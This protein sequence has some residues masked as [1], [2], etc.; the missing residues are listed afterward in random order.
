[1][2]PTR[3]A[4]LRK[5]LAI[6][7]ACAA[8]LTLPGLELY[9][10]NAD[11]FTL[12]SSAASA[13][14]LA[15]FLLCMSAGVL[16][17]TLAGKCRLFFAATAA[18]T[19][20]AL[21]M[22][23]Q[24]RL[25]CDCFPVEVHGTFAD[26]LPLA[27]FHA[28]MFLLPFV[29]ALVW[30]KKLYRH[31]G[32][33]AL[34]LLLVQVGSTLYPLC[35]RRPVAE[36]DFRE[37]TIDESAKFTFGKRDNIIVLVVDCMSERLAKQALRRYPELQ[38]LLKDFTAFDNMTSP[39]PR[40]PYA[41]PA[42][43]T[44]VEFPANP[45]GTP[46]DADHA[47]YLNRACRAPTSLFI[48]L[49]RFGFRTEGY[50]YIL[51]TVSYSP[52]VLDNS[53]PQQFEVQKDSA[54][55]IA[56][57]V[58]QRLIP[59]YLR[60]LVEEYYCIATDPFVV[61]QTQKKRNAPDEIFDQ[62]FRRRLNDEFTVGEAEKMFKYL[63]LHGA[64]TALRT[65]EDL[66]PTPNSDHLKQLRGSLINLELL[67]AKLKQAGL[68]DRAMLVV[69][70]DHTESYTPETITF[71]K[72]PGERHDALVFN[73]VPAKVK[74]IDAAILAAVDPAYAGQSLFDRPARP[75]DPN[76]ARAFRQAML[77][78]GKW[79]ADTRA[80]VPSATEICF[81][82]F[83]VTSDRRIR[84]EIE[85]AETLR[86]IRFTVENI[87][88]H[89]RVT[90]RSGRATGERCARTEPLELADGIYRVQL[91]PEYDTGGENSIVRQV[92][93]L[94]LIA[95]RGR[96]TF[97]GLPPDRPTRP[98]RPGETVAF[99][100]MEEYPQLV[101]PETAEFAGRMLRL[102][103]GMALGVRIPRSDRAMTLELAVPPPRGQ[104]GTLTVRSGDRQTFQFPIA[105]D[106]DARIRIPVAAGAERIVPVRLEFTPR[107]GRRALIT[108]LRH[109]AVK[110]LRLD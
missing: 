19:A 109:I 53:R 81:Q 32:R 8:V 27:G 87:D 96:L 77:E 84:F 91:E 63:H 70:G 10:A 45:D 25:W 72:R 102:P 88:T 93:P 59:F 55:K 54:I 13:L 100:P 39:L 35:G 17:L 41:V 89:E 18:L 61:V 67:I 4:V 2:K 79:Q 110:S 9:F 56:D 74:D 12:G 92:L 24:Y 51:Q 82:P 1:M 83:A 68:Y 60:P 21:A 20:F 64:H 69:T 44:G 50:P 3:R 36:Y 107:L 47:E 11:Q 98:L 26:D 90:A 73:A 75:G 40:T 62:V 105:A 30:R 106:T 28:V 101:L 14:T 76:K 5:I 29:P 38:E 85:A 86:H 15:A 16:V 95:R 52:D 31:I 99:T 80:D 49:K 42:M 37:Y 6:S 7:A 71:I 94:F 43:L 22:L 34:V 57:T 23:L 103:P 46:S 58:L 108:P 97:A 66:E 33:I 104:A 65:G 78:L 48:A